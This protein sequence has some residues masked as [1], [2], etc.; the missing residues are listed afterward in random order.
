MHESAQKR[1]LKLAMRKL[2]AVGKNLHRNFE[3]E[4]EGAQT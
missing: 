2:L 1:Q 3:D 4:T